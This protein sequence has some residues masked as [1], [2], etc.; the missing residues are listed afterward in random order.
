MVAFATIT[1]IALEMRMIMIVSLRNTDPVINDTVTKR[2]R[3]DGEGKNDKGYHYS[4]HNS[5]YE[6]S[7][8]WKVKSSIA[9]IRR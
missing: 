9:T 6:A 7:T 8:S 2:D 1:E 3:R 5:G 4:P